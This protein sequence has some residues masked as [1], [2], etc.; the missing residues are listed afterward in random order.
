MLYILELLVARIFECCVNFAAHL[1]ESI[2]RY[3]NAARLGDAFQSRR[4]VD[5]VAENITVLDDDVA[6]VNADA[7]FNTPLGRDVFVTLRHSALCL[8]GTT[9]GINGAAEFNQESVAGAFDDAAIVFGD[10]R[11]EE[12]P[13]MGIE[14]RECPFLVRAHEPAVS[15]DIRRKN[16][17][18]PPFHALFGHVSAPAGVSV[19]EVYGRAS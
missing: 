4:N 7:D 18:E 3:A 16:G 8:Y 1:P 12:F 13:T 17:S 15:S 19:R 11:F 10:S 5:A 9:R 6:D 14:P 2:F